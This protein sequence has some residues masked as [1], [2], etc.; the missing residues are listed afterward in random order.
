MRQTNLLVTTLREA[1]AE[2]ETRSHQL[3]L[4]AGYIRQVAAGVYTYL[5]LGRR[6]LRRIEQIVRQEMESAGA[7]EVLMPS[8]QPAELWRESERYEV[9]GKELMKLRDRHDREFVLGPTHEEVV[10]ALMRGEIS[11]YRRLQVTVYQI[12]TKFR[13][14]RRPRSGL[15]R[16]R[17]FLMKDAY[18]FDTDWNGL[19]LAY[20]VMY[21]AYERIFD[22]CG[23]KYQAVQANAGAIGGKGQNHEFMALS[24]IGEDTIAVCSLCGYAANLEQAEVQSGAAPHR[25]DYA[26]RPAPERFHTPA[27]KTIQQ[28]EQESQLRPQDIIKTLIYTGGGKI[29][30]VLVRGD[31]EVNE[32]KVQKYLGCGDI[33][34]ADAMHVQETAGTVSGYV[35]PA[36]LSMPLLVD[37]AVAAMTEAV[38]GAGEEDYHL[39]GVVPGRDFPLMQVGDFRN[40]VAGDCCPQCSEGELDFHQG[41]E[42]GHVF[43]LGTV[44]SEKLGADYLDADGRTRP[45]V[46]GCYGIGISRLLAAVA[47][48]SNDDQGLIWPQSLAPYTVHILLMSV[49]D[50]AQRELAE[51][52]YVRLTAL[53]IDTLLDDRDERAGVK[54][55][56]AGLMGIPVALV[57][58][59]LAAEQRV[60]YMDRRTGNK[61]V[62]DMSE[63]V[64]RV[65]SLKS[66]PDSTFA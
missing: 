46:M 59:K 54:F 24:E 36:G 13:D 33:T 9:Y 23:L 37:A 11:S 34:L 50:T 30:A 42:V 17:E 29:F 55:K 8:M 20:Q 3:L 62:I 15:L 56:D 58:G 21:S 39:R 10:T 32:L 40:A 12:Q 43:K 25:Q 19:D 44:Y 27:Q 41:I 53:G 48:Q 35:G 16:G 6:V 49:Q 38:T 63:A 60:E 31:H 65:S 4:R 51:A 66:A 57:V 45:M 22:R 52:L 28:L 2:A 61:E 1:P 47:E 7:Q 64:L 14:E 18:T 26:A 5:P